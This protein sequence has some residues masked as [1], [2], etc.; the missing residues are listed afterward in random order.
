MVGIW[1]IR[2]TE[3]FPL[4]RLH[5]HMI[6]TTIVEMNW[7]LIWDSEDDLLVWKLHGLPPS[8]KGISILYSLPSWHCLSCYWFE[9][10]IVKIVAK[11]LLQTKKSTKHE[12]AE[13][14]TCWLW[15]FCETRVPCIK[16]SCD[17]GDP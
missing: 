2:L 15:E 3:S 10:I 16:L 8:K 13:S 9:R 1:N 4:C 12:L 17:M 6:W 5:S 14:C 11:W 7:Y